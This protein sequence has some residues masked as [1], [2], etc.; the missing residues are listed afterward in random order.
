M[1]IVSIEEVVTW[2]ET[3]WDYK[4]DQIVK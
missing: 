3:K 1:E 2:W 4:M